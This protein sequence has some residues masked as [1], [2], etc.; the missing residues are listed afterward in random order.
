MLPLAELARFIV[1]SLD[2]LILQFISDPD[3]ARARRDL[4]VLADAVVGLAEGKT[5]GEFFLAEEK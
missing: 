1:G 5:V 4:A 3:P 2:G